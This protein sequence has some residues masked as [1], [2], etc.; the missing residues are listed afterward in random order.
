MALDEAMSE[1]FS[2]IV[3]GR[4][5]AVEL[6]R[7]DAGAEGGQGP[8][9]GAPSPAG[10]R[11]S[12]SGPLQGQL[13]VVVDGRE[14]L[15]DV[16]HL[17]GGMWS[18]VDSGSGGGARLLQVDGSGAKMTVEVT[19]PDGEPRICVVELPHSSRAVGQPGAARGEVGPLTLRAPIPG[20]LVKVL[21]KIGDSVKAGQTL[22]VLEA[23]KMENELRA[24]RAGVISAV[25]A[26]EGVA[27]EAGQDLISLGGVK[28]T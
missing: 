13:R 17:G 3:D 15:A 9:D 6:D 16:R 24:P 22:M 21:A 5:R 25:H 2:V 27:V 20:R 23:M 10:A 26:T 19:H 28:A 1:R 18:V 7:R 14:R 12:L 4:T 8:A 11:A